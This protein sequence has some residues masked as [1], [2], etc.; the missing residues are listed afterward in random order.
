MC[1]GLKVT[2]KVPIKKKSLNWPQAIVTACNS[3]IWR[4]HFTEP[5]V[6]SPVKIYILP[7]R[8]HL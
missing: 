3:T 2:R 1:C 4:F 8:G 5:R 6:L 7:D